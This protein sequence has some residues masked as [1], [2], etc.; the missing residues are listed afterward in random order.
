MRT[1]I[2]YRVE[3]APG[4]GFVIY[5]KASYQGMM[6]I[7]MTP[8]NPRSKPK[9]F[10]TADDVD[11]FLRTAEAEDLKAGRRL[12]VRVVHRRAFG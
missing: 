9:K 8:G 7:V 6:P 4:G 1:V 3:P 10:R 11:R 5:R 2:V 12:G